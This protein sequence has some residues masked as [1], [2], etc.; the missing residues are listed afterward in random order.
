MQA[1]TVLGSVVMPLDRPNVDTDAIIPKRFLK[2]IART[3]LGI[4]LFFDWRYKEDGSPKPD[5]VLN[6][7]LY[8]GNEDPPSAGEFRMRLVAGA[9]PLGPPRLRFPLHHRAVDCRHLLQQL[10]QERDTPGRPAR[11]RRGPPLP[12]RRKDA[13][14]PRERRPRVPVC[15][16]PGW[17]GPRIPDRPLPE[18]MPPEGL[19]EI[20]MALRR[21]P[22]IAAYEAPT[23]C[24]RPVAVRSPVGPAE[25]IDASRPPGAPMAADRLKSQIEGR[26]WSANWSLNANSLGR[27]SWT[28]CLT[29]SFTSG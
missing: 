2:T 15:H 7:P 19:D 24:R 18:G 25:T 14:L 10:L 1:F 12:Q 6:D 3:G 11:G 13:R 4:N 29:W 26:P 23:P 9:R 27:S 5:C 21:E 16:H 28:R 17:I 22:E 20:G 8:P